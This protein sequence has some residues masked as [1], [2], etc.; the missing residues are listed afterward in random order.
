MG[1]G[2]VSPLRH[3]ETA[4]QIRCGRTGQG[5]L[6]ERRRLREEPLQTRKVDVYER[7]IRGFLDNFFDPRRGGM[8]Q[9]KLLA[10]M[11]DVT[12]DLTIWASDDV[13]A[14]WSR[15]RRRWAAG[16]NSPEASEALQ[17]LEALFLAIRQDL[18]H[19]T[20]AS[21]RGTSWGSGSTTSSQRP[22][23]PLSVASHLVRRLEVST[24]RRRRDGAGVP[25]AWE[26]TLVSLL[27]EYQV[28]QGGVDELE[29]PGAGPSV[30]CKGR[31]S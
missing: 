10:F 22:K 20:K 8:D 25:G 28:P 27:R 4:G 6:S 16:E 7:F 24:R 2:Y 11:S 17:E 29:D 23:K 5:G 21:S 9:A 13:L 1:L 15:L 19:G 26:P 12:P 3:H 18:R 30:S 14:R 31:W